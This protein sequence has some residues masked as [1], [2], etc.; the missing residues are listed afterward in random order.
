[1]RE[2]DR[3]EMDVFEHTGDID[4]AQRVGEA[5]REAVVQACETLAEVTGLSS[6]EFVA[7]VLRFIGIADED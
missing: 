1:M 7:G 4:L 5:T 3:F 6:A 2:I